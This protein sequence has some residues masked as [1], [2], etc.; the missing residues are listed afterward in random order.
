MQSEPYAIGAMTIIFGEIN[1][2]RWNWEQMAWE[3]DQTI[4]S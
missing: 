1:G 2:H 3:E 4:R